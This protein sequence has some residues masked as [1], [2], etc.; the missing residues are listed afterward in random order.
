MKT[1]KEL[2]IEF[3][4]KFEAYLHEWNRL[5]AIRRH[6]I[7]RT[8]LYIPVGFFLEMRVLHLKHRLTMEYSDYLEKYAEMVVEANRLTA[9]RN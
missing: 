8:V 1:S 4:T 5:N 3:L 6:W 9:E 7:L 2:F